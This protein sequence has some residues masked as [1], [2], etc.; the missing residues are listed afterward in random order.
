MNRN[1]PIYKLRRKLQYIAYH[2][3][4]H[5]TLSK[6]YF[7]ILV[8]EKLNLKNPQTFNEKLQWLKLYYFPKNSTVVQCA[9]KYQVRKYIEEK[10]L[11]EKLVDLLGVW[12]KAEDIE[13][14]KL[15]DKFVLKCT[16]GCAYNIVCKDKKNFDKK[17][18]TKQLNKWLK[19]DFAAFN[20]ELHYGKNKK[21]RI[22]AESFLGDKLIDYK[23]F[24]FNGKPEFLYIS[25]D[26]INDRQAQIGFFDLE[27]KKM[28]LVRE[29]YEDIGKNVKIPPF[30]NEM[31]KTAK[32]LSRDFPFVRV[33]FFD[34]SKNY[35]FAELTF[36][37]CAAM[38]P[39]NPKKYD[40]E[41]GKKLD[42]SKYQLKK[43]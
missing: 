33:D 18:A 9:D 34:A 8:H 29:E 22:I 7:R 39:I 38:M 24:C 32:I 10:G 15:P 3:L 20:V 28:P 19:E 25:S 26:L 35:V 30:L 23:F 41:W 14:E 4:P 13:W 1:N 31:I 27:G 21:R 40:I 36:T 16:H 12:E 42:I 5:E 11:K 2:V 17:K 37:P 43:K 6:I